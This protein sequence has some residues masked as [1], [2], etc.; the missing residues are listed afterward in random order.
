MP[1]I[2]YYR[3]YICQDNDLQPQQIML[4]FYTGDQPEDNPTS[5]DGLFRS[6]W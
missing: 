4:H 6:V 3:S 2:R 5:I 1:K